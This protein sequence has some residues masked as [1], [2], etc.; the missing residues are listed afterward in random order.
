MT[1]WLF[2]FSFCSN[3]SVPVEVITFL[4]C[5]PQDI[6]AYRTKGTVD[7][8]SARAAEDEDDEDEDEEGED[9]EDEEEDDDDE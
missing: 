8:G 4:S 5:F 6:V 9:E 1:R 7:P 3:T 2:I